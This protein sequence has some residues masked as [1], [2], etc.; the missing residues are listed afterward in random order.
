LRQPAQ[1]GNAREPHGAYPKRL[2]TVEG[3]LEQWGDAGRRRE[4]K[5]SSGLC[6]TSNVCACVCMIFASFGNISRLDGGGKPHALADAWTHARLVLFNE[7]TEGLPN[8]ACLDDA[9]NLAPGVEAIGSYTRM[10]KIW[11]MP[12]HVVQ[13]V[14]QER[15]ELRIS[16]CERII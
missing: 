14:A 6:H 13:R 9:E 7:A 2:E 1:P 8:L 16:L 5:H 12:P 3:A 10:P 4:R 11:E 15:C